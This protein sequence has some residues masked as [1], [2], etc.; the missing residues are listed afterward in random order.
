MSQPAA[1]RAG[2]REV[3]FAA[4]VA[5]FGLLLR[6]S[7][8]KGTASYDSVLEI[9]SSATG[10]DVHGYRKELLEIVRQ[11]MDLGSR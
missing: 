9:A 5:E 7:E 4:A 10:A 11:A 8:H 3:R 1:R 6:N 2:G